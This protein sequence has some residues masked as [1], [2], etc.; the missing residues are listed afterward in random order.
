MKY[1]AR[2]TLAFGVLFALFC[3]GCASYPEEQLK[4]AQAAMDEAL[5]YKPEVFA[6]SD[7]QDAKKIWDEAQSLLSQQ[8][9]AQASS[10]LVTAKSRLAKVAQIASRNHETVLSEVTKTQMEISKRHASLKSD[11]A[12]AR[13]SPSV[14]KSLEECCLQLEQKIGQLN[15]EVETGDLLKAQ[16]TAKETLKFVYEGQLKMDAVFKKLP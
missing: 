10:L 4:Q 11:L 16:A 1:L 13:L 2:C 9:Y 12:A 3:I 8:K 15:T 5:K 6:A 7:W 14:R